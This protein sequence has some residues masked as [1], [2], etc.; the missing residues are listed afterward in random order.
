MAKKVV[1]EEQALTTQ[2]TQEIG[3]AFDYGEL[4]V[5][6][7]QLA[8]GYENQTSEDT[9]L[10]FLKLCQSN[11][12]EVAESKID[13][14]A[15]GM[16]LN[17]VTGRFWKNPK[18]LLFVPSQT[19]HEY[20][21]YTPRDEGGGF[22]ARHAIDSQVVAKA[23]AESKSFGEYYVVR[24]DGGKNELSETFYVFGVACDEELPTPLGMCVIAFK[25]SM[26]KCYKSW[27]TQIRSHTIDQGGQKKSPPL[28]SHLARFT[29]EGKK[30]D[31]GFFHV[32]VYTPGVEGSVARSC[33]GPTDERF[34][35]AYAC[36]KM[37]DAGAAKVNYEKQEGGGSAGELPKGPDGKPIF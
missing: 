10:P 27:M 29:T 21:E 2:G 26:I 7:G 16:W 36:K 37:V 28:F 11:T 22:V 8:P 13:G 15:A 23:K 34:L 25:S 14:L 19:T 6:A 33:L 5:P 4:A 32:P 3:E 1:A 18:G 24:E 12:P 31:Q 17:T 35:M 30:N 20:T 9:A